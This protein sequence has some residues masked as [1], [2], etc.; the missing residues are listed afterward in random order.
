MEIWQK[1]FTWNP[2]C[3]I[4]HF[5]LFLVITTRSSWTISWT[6]TATVYHISFQLHNLWLYVPSLHVNKRRSYFTLQHFTT[7]YLFKYF[8]LFT[9][10]FTECLAIAA[11]YINL[12]K[13]KVHFWDWLTIYCS[14][15]IL[16]LCVQLKLWISIPFTFSVWEKSAIYCS[17]EDLAEQLP[18][19]RKS[20]SQLFFTYQI[21]VKRKE[22]S[23]GDFKAAT[24]AYIDRYISRGM[25]MVVKCQASDDLRCAVCWTH[26][27]DSQY[28][29]QDY[30]ICPLHTADCC[31]TEIQRKRNR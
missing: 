15:F 5:L 10:S 1:R 24:L 22:E 12:I 16:N 4:I 3:V 14:Q 28:C 7:Y 26:T 31:S 20:I 8:S 6:K 9:S 18:S 23:Q 25:H 13:F 21:T 29:L 2:F 27:I 30:D 11:C 17:L 19:N